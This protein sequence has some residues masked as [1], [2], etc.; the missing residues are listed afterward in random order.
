MEQLAGDAV[1]LAIAFGVRFSTTLRRSDVGESW[2]ISL[3]TQQIT[4]RRKV[5]YISLV[6]PGTAGQEAGLRENDV[7]ASVAGQDVYC[8]DVSVVSPIFKGSDTVKVG[9]YRCV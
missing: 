3:T 1:Y 7:I 5:V 2:G 4:S 6:N 8:F 9:F